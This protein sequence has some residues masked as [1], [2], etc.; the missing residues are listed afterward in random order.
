M[1]TKTPRQAS[2]WTSEELEAF[3][4]LTS[5]AKI[6]AF[7]DGLPYSTEYLYRCPRSVLRDRKAHCYDGALFA[8][9]ALHRLGY[10]PVIVNMLA[11]RDDEHLVALYQVDR[12]WGAVGKSNVVGLRFREAVYRSLRELLMSYFEPYFNV[13]GLRSLRSYLLPLNL[14]TLGGL[15]WRTEDA[16]M[17]EIAHKLNRRRK[18]WLV[19]PEMVARLSPV[20][21]RSYTAG[22]MGSDDAGLYKPGSRG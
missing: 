14:N 5:P 16:A 22:F 3:S 21:Q 15:P 7:L 19:T 2:I 12:H 11:E 1:R 10:P 17:D 4:G 20:D 6:Q 8:A 13:E 9:A 18:V